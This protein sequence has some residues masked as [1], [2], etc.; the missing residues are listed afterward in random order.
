MIN[1]AY[2]SSGRENN[3]LNIYWTL[4]RCTWTFES[5]YAL[6]S[7]YFYIF[8]VIFWWFPPHT[9][10]MTTTSSTGHTPHTPSPDYHV[11]PQS[12]VSPFFLLYFSCDSSPSY[13]CI[14]QGQLEL[15]NISVLDYILPLVNY[16]LKSW[17]WLHCN[18]QDIGYT[19]ISYWT[20]YWIHLSLSII[21][22]LC[23][24]LII[25]LYRH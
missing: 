5:I 13:A 21:T 20:I 11:W 25:L 2:G 14:N 15:Y 4:M 23:S 18:L 17:N 22:A 24:Q 8:L 12:P 10:T 3:T 6:F 9:D 19:A 16:S 1:N 7:G